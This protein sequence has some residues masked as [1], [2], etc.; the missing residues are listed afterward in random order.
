MTG[1]E[2]AVLLKVAIAATIASTAIAVTSSIQQGKAQE[3][4]AKASAEFNAAKARDEAQQKAAAGRIEADRIRR[5]RIRLTKEQRAEGGAS[6][7]TSEGT[8]IRFMIQ[9]AGEEE[10]N[11]QMTQHNFEVGAAASRSAAS[12]QDFK[13]NQASAFKRAG[14]MQAGASLLSGIAQAGLISAS[15]KKTA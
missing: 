11:A 6:G 14:N 4:S 7:L 5:A 3:R 15:A 13:K 8:P 10:L 9:S 2:T 1:I 12:V